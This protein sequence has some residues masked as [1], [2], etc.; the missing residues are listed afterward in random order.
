MENVIKTFLSMFFIIILMILGIGV[1]NASIDGRNADS[2]LS[3]VVDQIEASNFSTRVIESQFDNTAALSINDEKTAFIGKS[4]EGG[5]KMTINVYR[6]S[7]NRTV[8]Y[9]TCSI[10]YN[11]SI[12]FLGKVGTARTLTKDIR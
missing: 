3:S 4:K 1:V 5:Y 8:K 10:S 6:S 9:G 11:F 2:Y 12:P 7:D